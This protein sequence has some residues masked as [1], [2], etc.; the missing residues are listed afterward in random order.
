MFQE[1]PGY[2]YLPHTADVKFEAEG[3]DLAEAFKNAAIASFNV[4]VNTDNVEPKITKELSIEAKRDLSLLYD[5][6]DELL[7]L[8]DTEGFLLAE[9]KEITITDDFKLKATIVGDNHSQDNKYDVQGNVKSVTYNDMEIIKEDNKVK[10]TV[11]LD[12]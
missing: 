10:L 5:F 2:K 11:V 8:L 12:L 4:I 3:K 1:R 6:L 7:F 9:V